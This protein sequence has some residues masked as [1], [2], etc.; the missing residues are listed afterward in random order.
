MNKPILILLA[1]LPLLLT[2]C[3][4]SDRHGSGYGEGQR[5]NADGSI[6]NH[7]YTRTYYY[8]PHSPHDAHAR[9]RGGEGNQ[10]RLYENASG[11]SNSKG[12]AWHYDPNS[13]HDV[14]ARPRG[15]NV[16]PR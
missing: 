2:S 6:K 14:Y 9:L 3:I 12:L 4:I 11:Y 15:R 8:D 7:Y 10:Y 16:G 1:A 13:T 5:W